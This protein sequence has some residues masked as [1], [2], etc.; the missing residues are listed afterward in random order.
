MEALRFSAGT[1]SPVNA[2]SLILRRGASTRR[3]SAGTPLPASIKTM[4]PRTISEAAIACRRPPVR[5]GLSE[6]Q[7]A[8]APPS[9]APRDSLARSRSRRSPRLDDG[10]C[11]QNQNH[12]VF[13]LRSEHSD[14]AAAPLFAYL[15]GSFRGKAARRLLRRRPPSTSEPSCRATLA[16]VEACHAGGS[17]TRFGSDPL[18]NSPAGAPLKKTFNGAWRIISQRTSAD[19]GVPSNPELGFVAPAAN[20]DRRTARSRPLEASTARGSAGS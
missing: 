11:D 4:S 2:A 18:F 9:R 12:E 1:A 3:R 16:A 20:G 15:V 8:A 17:A 7:A 13:K 10:G 14:D 5:R 6:Q 19:S